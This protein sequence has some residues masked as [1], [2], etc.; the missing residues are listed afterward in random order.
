MDLSS[1]TADEVA[2]YWLVQR[3]QGMAVETDPRF[4]SWLATSPNHAQVWDRTMALWNSFDGNSDPLLKAMRQDALAARRPAAL[5]HRWLAIAASAVLMMVAGVAGWQ[6][7]E[8]RSKL[9]HLAQFVPPDAKPTFVATTDP[10]TFVLPD[11]SIVTLNTNTALA[12]RYTTQRRA[13]RL[14]KGQAFFRVVHNSARPFTA[15]VGRSTVSDLGTEF[16]ILMNGRTLSVTLASGSVAVATEGGSTSRTL[17]PGQRLDATPGQEDRS[18]P[19]VLADALAWRTKYIELHDEPLEKAITEFNR[20]GGPP[21]GI[22]DPA[23][24]TMRVSGRFRTGDPSRFARTLAE[25]YPLRIVTRPDG[26][27]DLQKR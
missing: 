17:E 24:R 12:V 9:Q 5:S 10:E 27:V 1:A 11:G 6:I 7:L 13:V 2:A 15:D 19:V 23:I 16:D 8:S 18:T 25:I 4:I 22:T 14:L 21:V 26:G 3:D 20:Y